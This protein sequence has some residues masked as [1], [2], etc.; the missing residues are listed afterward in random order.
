MP[1][2]Y[3]T[4]E[5]KIPSLR[6]FQ[7]IDSTNEEG[8]RWL[9]EGAVEYSTII[10]NAQTAGRGRYGREW[11]TTPQA[12]LA[13]SMIIYPTPAEVNFLPLFSP[14]GALAVCL[15]LQDLSNLKPEIK[16]PNDVLVQQHKIAG[17]LAETHWM[18]T[19]LKGLVIGMG[20]NIAKESVPPAHQMLFPVASI[21]DFCHTK[22]KRL[23]LL[24]KTIQHF[25]AQRVTI[26][27]G[28]LI[29]NWQQRLAFIGKPVQIKD[30]ETILFQ[31]V[32]QGLDENGW[33]VLEN[34]EERRSIPLGDLHLRPL[35][36][37][38]K[39]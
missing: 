17:V 9:N 8:L 26:T 29:N 24:K 31:G 10:A 34:N 19:Y 3:L 25:I 4:W 36:A 37:N 15:A 28:A 16:W 14:L 13:F 35:D 7:S 27:S 21:E 18:E 11:V 23:Q 5:L 6:R 1:L 20:I 32:L 39:K 33:L 12:S 22:I 30:G 38:Q 2:D